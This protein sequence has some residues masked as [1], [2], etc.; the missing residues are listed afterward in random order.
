MNYRKIYVALDGSDL[1]NAAA[2]LAVRIGA[3]E[4]AELIGSHVYAARMHDRRFRAMESGLPVKYQEENEL[5]KQREVHDSLIERGLKLISDSYLEEV[6]RTCQEHGLSFTG[7]SLEG[8]N[9]KELAK[10]I[11][12]HDYDLVALG[13]CGVGRVAGSLLGSVADRLLRRVRR[14]LLICKSDSEEDAS[15]EIVVCLDGSERSWGGLMRGIQLGK[16][17]G[18]KLVAIAAFDPYFHYTMFNTLSGVLSD[19]ARKVFKFEEQEKLHEDIIDAGLAKIYQAHL[20]IA[21]RLAGD[22]K[23]EIETHLLD[24]KAHQKVLEFVRGRRPWL[25]ILGRLGIHSDEDMDI[26]SNT[27][28]VCRLADCNLLVV[29]GKFKPPVEYQAEETVAWTKEATAQMEMVPAMARKVATRAIQDYCL[30]E[31]HTVITTSLLHAAIRQI[32]P[33]EAMARMGIQPEDEPRG[34]AP[35]EKESFRCEGCGHVHHGRRPQTCQVCGQAGENFTLVEE[36]DITD[37]VDVRGFDGR[38][39]VWEKAALRALE[40]LADQVLQ[41]QIRNKVEK[42]ARTR[43]LSTIT[44]S[45]VTESL[46]EHRG[47]PEAARPSEMTDRV[48]TEA[49]L[50]RLERVPAGFMRNAAKKSIEDYAAHRGLS[51]ITLQLAED[52]LANAREQMATAMAGGMPGPLI[53]AKD[54]EKL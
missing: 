4:G 23:L 10:D 9:W 22:E 39:L 45:M 34:E 24:G 33:P 12:A 5:E 1:S 53:M 19:Q 49:A 20:D 37:G 41:Q 51:E 38:T 32:L 50:K 25:L 26:G 14:D 16:A 30:A 48:W 3:H 11:D 35:A 27:E 8:R 21:K 15:D 7:V 29:E 40:G 6:E 2:R 31:G 54:H 43:R 13:A 46:N 44:L 17:F 36:E 47:A 42:Q 18:K 28:N 52:G